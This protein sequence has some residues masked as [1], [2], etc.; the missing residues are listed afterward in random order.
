MTNYHIEEI[1]GGF[2]VV[3]TRRFLWWK[4]EKFIDVSAYH[5]NIA[6]LWFNDTCTKDWF[7]KDSN[8]FKSMEDAERA[9]EVCNRIL[10]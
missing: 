3:Q 8:C 2:T 6:F 10:K 4:R 5:C 9:L 1:G 7:K